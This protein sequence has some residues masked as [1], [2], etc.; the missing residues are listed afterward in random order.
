MNMLKKLRIWLL[1][2]AEG[3]AAAMLAAMFLT[4]V[5]Q[6][7]SRYIL[8]H[9]FGWTLEVCLTLWLWLVFWSNSFVI[10]HDE[11]VTF[12]ILYHSVRP[13][14]RR[15][16]SLIGSASIVI[17]MAV[18]FP[19]TWDFIDFLE[20]KDSPILQVPMRTVFSIYAVFLISVIASYAWRFIWTLRHGVPEEHP[21]YKSRMVE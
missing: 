9:S 15:I 12:D 16:F 8:N 17:G 5:L 20:I 7:F 14:L 13:K 6:I 18:S 19:A 2:G 4:F 11:H 21:E 10:K 1:K 3:V